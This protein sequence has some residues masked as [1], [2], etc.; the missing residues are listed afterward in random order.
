MPV[1]ITRRRGRPSTIGIAIETW[2]DDVGTWLQEWQYGSGHYTQRSD[3]SLNQYEVVIDKQPDRGALLVA[4][5]LK[6]AIF[7]RRAGGFPPL[8]NIKQ[9]IKDKPID[10][11]GDISIDSLAFLIGRKIAE[12]G[13]DPPKLVR[14]NLDLVINNFGKKHMDTLADDLVEEI[15]NGLISGIDTRR[16]K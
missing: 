11:S 13:T 10:I 5:N 3:S 6:W 1:K 8:D 16:M 14:Q 4:D 12:E 15:A 2:L 9:W 7:G